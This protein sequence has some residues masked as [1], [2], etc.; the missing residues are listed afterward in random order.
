MAV[1]EVAV[2][3]EAEDL[4]FEAQ[5]VV[6]HTMGL[7]LYHLFNQSALLLAQYA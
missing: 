1:V 4:V 2:E 6:H 7:P 3:A 5:M